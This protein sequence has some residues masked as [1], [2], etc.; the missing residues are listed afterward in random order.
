MEFDN[1]KS[2]I[3]FFALLPISDAHVMK[4]ETGSYN[5]LNFMSMKTFFTFKRNKNKRVYE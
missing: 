3:I 4:I 1:N 2:T 5:V